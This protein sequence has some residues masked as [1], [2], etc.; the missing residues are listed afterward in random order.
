MR[1][2]MIALSIIFLGAPA[3]SAQ[4]RFQRRS[5]FYTQPA[6]SQSYVSSIQVETEIATFETY[7]YLFPG[8]DARHIPL[9][10]ITVL[11]NPVGVLPAGPPAVI[12]LWQA[13]P[14]LV[15]PVPALAQPPVPPVPPV[16]AHNLPYTP[17]RKNMYRQ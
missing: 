6:Y 11:Q 15:P 4:H 10:H 8:A 16:P 5:G 13:Q 12:E 9:Q 2:F 3:V 14:L 17:L 1:H 7:Q